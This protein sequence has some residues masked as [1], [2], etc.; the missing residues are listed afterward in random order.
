MDTNTWI[1]ASVGILSGSLGTLIVTK[2]IDYFSEKRIFNQ[3]L[4]RQFFAKKLEAAEKA[5][6]F[7]ISGIK[8]NKMLQ[9]SL[10]LFIKD[11]DVNYSFALFQEATTKCKSL[12]DISIDQVDMISLYFDEPEPII[13]YPVDNE[14]KIGD[15]LSK[16]IKKNN[17]AN[18]LRVELK[19]AKIIKQVDLVE[20]IEKRYATLQEEAKQIAEEL[21]KCL[22]FEKRKDA[23]LVKF[24]HDELKQYN[25]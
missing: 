17:E 8:S 9:Y 1:L 21:I 3:E 4:K 2:I 7:F 5:T 10:E 25:M 18:E 12:W 22:E 23:Y 13:W 16:I 6:K 20:V 14:S 15:C 19:N 11:G 24:I